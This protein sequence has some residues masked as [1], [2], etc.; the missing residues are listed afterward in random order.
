MLTSKQIRDTSPGSCHDGSRNYSSLSRHSGAL[1]KAAAG[2]RR[3]PRQTAGGTAPPRRQHRAAACG[4]H[5][6]TRGTPG[7]TAP[8]PAPAPRHGRP[9]ITKLAAALPAAVAAFSSLEPSRM[10]SQLGRDWDGEL[11]GMDAMAAGPRHC[12]MDCGKGTS[13]RGGRQRTSSLA[14][15]TGRSA[16]LAARRARMLRCTSGGSCGSRS[17]CWSLPVNAWQHARSELSPCSIRDA[18][19]S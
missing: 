18:C 9:L 13:C 1:A 8:T 7:C 12:C 6:A 19:C 5:L 15:R 16:Q 10:W 2:P 3:P 17:V 14:S 11:M 4:T